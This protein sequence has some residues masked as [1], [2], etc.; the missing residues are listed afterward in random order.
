MLT[1]ALTDHL[2]YIA[3]GQAESDMPSDSA[4]LAVAWCTYLESHMRRIYGL[5]GDVS[6]RA[7]TELAKK[8]MA[9]SLQDRF[10]V[11]DVYRQGWYLLNT[12]DAVA[13]ACDELEEA[14]WIRKIQIP[15]EG[16]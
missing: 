1:I 12:K 5:I 8:L 4:T 6:Q 15:I 16:R 9:G 11:R 7:A 13:M 3:D 2:A 14:N 10:S